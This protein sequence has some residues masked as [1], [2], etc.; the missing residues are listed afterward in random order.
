MMKTHLIALLAAVLASGTGAMASTI[1][2]LEAQ[3]SG[4][5]GLTADN[6][7]GAF[8]VITAI[9]S[10]PG[11]VNGL[12]Y[13][14]WAFLL[15]DGTGSVEVFGKLPTGSTY[16][17]TVGDAIS[18][19]GTYSPF[20]QIP[21][22]ASL[23]AITQQS[24]GHV[25]PLPAHVSIPDVNVNPLPLTR[26]GYLLEIDNVTITNTTSSTTFGSSTLTLGITD[27][28]NSMTM[29]YWPTSYS[30]ANSSLSGMTIPTG[31]VDIIGI[32]DVF[33]TN[34]GV[35]EF[36]PMTIAAAP[37]PASLGLLAVGG[38]ALIARRRKGC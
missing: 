13:T 24:T 7:S 33:G 9:L 36:V 11:T 31:P 2:S 25:A 23:T 38:L 20:N 17:P 32:A 8:P 1:A 35:P 34:P 5:A 18:A 21:E 29:F 19:T 6:A 26:G 22:L 28:T 27:G 16:T 10:K 3:P 15:N 4:T 12:T 30:V 14:N 37:E